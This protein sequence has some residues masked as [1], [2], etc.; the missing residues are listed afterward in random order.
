MGKTAIPEQVLCIVD[1]LLTI[2]EEGR[3]SS[4]GPID[5]QDLSCIDLSSWRPMFLLLRG[6]MLPWNQTKLGTFSVAF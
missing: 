4:T 1:P 6:K 2:A 5:R 3:P